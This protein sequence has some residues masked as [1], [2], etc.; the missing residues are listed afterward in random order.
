MSEH[1]GFGVPILEA[2]YNRIPVVGYAAG[3]VEETMNGGGVVLRA[4]DF[5]RTAA[6]IDAIQRDAGLRDRIV[7]G[8]L[9]ALKAF[10]RENVSRILLDLVDE[11]R[12]A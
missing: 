4:K 2:F 8:Q 7:A 12:R 6:L 5:L 10:S 3:A 1:E 9:E 11:A